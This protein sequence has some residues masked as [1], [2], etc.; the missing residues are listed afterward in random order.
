MTEQLNKKKNKRNLT[1]G[2]IPP[3]MLKMAGGMLFGLIA[4]SAFN[5]VDT[6][7]VGRLGATELA[8]M[9]YTFPVVLVLNSIALG[10]G[11]GLSSTVSRAIGAG[12]QHKVKRLTTDGLVLSLLV[13]LIVGAA[14]ILTIEPL[15]SLIGAEGRTLSL[16]KDYMTI[17]YIG[18]PFVVI[19]MAGN[20]VIRATGDTL[21]PSLIMIVSV[22]VNTTLDP[23]L[24]FGIGPFPALGIRGAALATVTARFTTLLF[25]LSILAFREK[26]LSSEI[27][28]REEILKN[29]KQ[30]GFIGVPAALVQAIYP[31]SLG[32]LTGILAVFGD[33]VVAGFGAAGRL[34]FLILTIPNSLGTVMAPFAGQN[35]GAKKIDRIKEGARFSS[36]V[37]L[38]WGGIIFLVFLFSADSIIGLFSADPVVIKAGGTYLKIM[39]SGYG[40]FGI[41]RITTQSLNAVNKPLHSATVTLIKAFVINIPLAYLGGRFFNETG[42]FTSSLIANIA[43]GIIGLSVFFHILRRNENLKLRS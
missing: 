28:K 3:L 27:P 36:L 35:W 11:V 15:F 17:W 25:S 7:F 43:G 14:G 16:I 39:G 12:D 34:D 6:Y 5:A 37:S 13:V 22:I 30:I 26:L 24:I 33:K 23:L 29:W 18:I 21:I 20:N 1:E 9:S 38:L 8:A 32:I 40:F 42:V 41:L 2:A 31:L 10:L 19:P 4:M